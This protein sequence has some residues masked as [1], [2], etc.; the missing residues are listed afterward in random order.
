MEENENISDDELG[1]EKESKMN[2][3]DSSNFSKKM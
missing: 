1:E 3:Y 2:K